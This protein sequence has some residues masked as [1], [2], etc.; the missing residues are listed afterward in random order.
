M[1]KA[2]EVKIGQKFSRWKILYE[3]PLYRQPNGRTCRMFKCKCD[4]GNELDVLLNTMRNGRSKSC[5]CLMKELNG[6][7]LSKMSLT[8]GATTIKRNKDTS[9]FFVWNTMKQRC[10]NSKS[11]KYKNYGAKGIIVCEDWLNSFENFRDWAYNNGYICQEKS[12]NF[13]EKLSIDRI[14]VNG[15]Y[16]PENCRWISISDNTKRKHIKIT[17]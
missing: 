3:L 16:T 9:L 4:C 10:Y 2:I 5:G 14:D 17:K 7:R 8:H 12:I 13:A 1:P 11:I 6:I 15:N